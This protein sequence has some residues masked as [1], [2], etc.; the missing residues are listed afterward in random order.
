MIQSVYLIPKWETGI[1]YANTAAHQLHS[2][3]PTPLNASSCHLHHRTHR[4]NIGN[5]EIVCV[6]HQLGNKCLCGIERAR[7]WRK[8]GDMGPGTTHTPNH[9]HTKHC[10]TSA[11]SQTNIALLRVS[12]GF[13]PPYTCIYVCIMY[14]LHIYTYIRVCI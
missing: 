4:W 2:N 9:C 1:T 7:I 11:R 13:M 6:P 10:N 5:G 12:L 14:I 3:R 8:G